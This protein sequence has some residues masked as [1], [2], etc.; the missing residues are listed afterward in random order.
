MSVLGNILYIVNKS[1]LEWKK[2]VDHVEKT[3]GKNLPV[4]IASQEI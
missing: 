3:F 4:N 1:N 2:G